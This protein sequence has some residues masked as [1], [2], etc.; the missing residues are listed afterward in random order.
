MQFDAGWV[1]FFKNEISKDYFKKLG[2]T[3]HNHRLDGRTIYPGEGDIFN[4]FKMTPHAKVKAVI[5]GGEP[6][7]KPGLEHG[8]AFSVR[9]GVIIPSTLNNIF[10]ELNRDLNVPIPQHGNLDHWAKS[11]I[12]LLNTVLTT[13]KNRPGS[14]R[15][16]GWEKFTDSVLAYLNESKRGLVF[17]L[18]GTEA[19]AK[20][21]GLNSKRHKILKTSHP[22]NPDDGF[23]GCGHFSH[24]NKETGTWK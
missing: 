23:Y 19:Q 4:A 12:L 21:I 15:N 24:I 22:D 13:E 11:G 3:I 5:V 2:G 20:G 6:H 8:L 1:Q 18:W 7:A 17:C 10:Q 9:K 14:H 16:A